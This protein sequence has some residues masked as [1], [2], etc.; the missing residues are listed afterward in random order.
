MPGAPIAAIEALV[1]RRLPRLQGALPGL[2]IDP[3]ELAPFVAAH[4]R[5]AEWAARA[6]DDDALEPL[7]ELAL[8]HALA[9][10]DRAALDLF[11]ARY[12]DGVGR[13]LARLRL[14]PGELDEVKQRV[15]EKLLVPGEGRRLRLEEYV[16][17]GRLGGLVQVMATRE[18]I[19]LARRQQRE[20]PAGDAALGDRAA[21]EGWDAGVEL[22]RAEYRAA[23]REA[24]AA[25]VA[26]LEP[27]ERNLLR[28][29]LL[30]G[31]T[32]EHL[33]SIYDVHR[34]TV[35]RW[36]AA[37]R[38]KV[39][40]AT[41]RGLKERLALRSDELDSMMASAQS[42]LDVSVERFFATRDR[43]REPEG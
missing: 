3:G 25:A 30:G 20:R 35:V 5:G 39:L 27:R 34:A 23:F 29:H 32:L 7:A 37:A 2:R 18:A 42:R 28:L 13:A 17:L 38:E 33:A 10:G 21:A 26:A 6:G 12:L 19:S 16:G 36:L 41:R 22:G 31:A 24:F 15:R 43:G 8:A 11:E 14:D 4:P 40:D 9:R 1:A